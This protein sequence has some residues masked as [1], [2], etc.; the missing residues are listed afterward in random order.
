MASFEAAYIYPLGWYWFAEKAAYME[1]DDAYR[2]PL[3][4]DRL[5]FKAASIPPEA[6][7]NTVSPFAETVSLIPT[8][9]IDAPILVSCDPEVAIILT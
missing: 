1:P 4:M 8:P 7:T 6:A 5:T 2:L 9:D 3:R